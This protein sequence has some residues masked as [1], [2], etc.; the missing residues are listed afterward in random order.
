MKHLEKPDKASTEKRYNRR[1][2]LKSGLAVTALVGLAKAELIFSE[3]HKTLHEP[4]TLEPIS[5][6]DIQAQC[7]TM[8]DI[9]VPI[10]LLALSGFGGDEQRNIRALQRLTQA[11]FYVD[12][13]EVIQRAY[14]RFAGTDNERLQDIS[15]FLNTPVEQLP[16]ILLG[17]RGG[18][19]AMR[20]LNRLS[21]AEWRSLSAKFKERGTL[22][23]GFSD[24]TAIQLA[25]MAQGNLPYIAGAMLNSDFGKEVVNENTIQSFINICTQ[26]KLTINIT[27]SQPYQIKKQLS[28]ILWGGNLSVLSALVGTPFLPDVNGGILFIEDVGEQPY[29]IERLLQ[30]LYLSGVLAKQ[31]AIVLGKFNFN[32]ISDAYDGDYTFD[33]VLKY[34][35]QT[36]KLP[37]YTD[38]PFGHV[39]ER[40]NFPL[41]VP[42]TL[43]KT[44][45]GYQA[46][47]DQLPK[48]FPNL[49]QEKNFA[50]LKLTELMR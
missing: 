40:I 22:L 33:T 23:S 17:V 42:V 37:I 8:R 19:G 49:T 11:G 6:T 24:F 39:A 50:N 45:L 5:F 16:K 28:G 34:I 26:D 2:L 20:L 10:H 29:R 27:Q 36:T 3:R 41:G 13:P 15:V 47:F 9:G 18:Y 35:Q 14:L 1:F 7:Q 31:Q 46:I 21:L 25:M 43:Q 48:N 12:N 32:G 30:T 38:F 4:S 44:M